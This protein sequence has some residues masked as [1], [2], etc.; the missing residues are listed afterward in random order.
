MSK[1]ALIIDDNADF[2]ASV[3]DVL[4]ANGYEVI[5]ASTGEE[6]FAK[7]VDGSPDVIFLD[8]MMENADSG[9]DTVKKL[10]NESKTEKIPVFLITG[11][12][13]PQFLM[14]SYAPDE[15]FTNVKKIFE[16]P[17][18]PATLIDALDQV[19]S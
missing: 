5:D 15:A 2:T 4:T 3:S 13:K 6:G 9:L 11:I 16:K 8:V 10:K 1:K 17:V 12:K 19:L 18:E 14:Q 7:A